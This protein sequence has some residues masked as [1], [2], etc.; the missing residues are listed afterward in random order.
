MP[1]G[2][3]PCRY[4]AADVGASLVQARSRPKIMP[5]QGNRDFGWSVE[6]RKQ[7]PNEKIEDESVAPWGVEEWKG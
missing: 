7:N 3:R 6:R 4:S 2:T 5:A 1:A